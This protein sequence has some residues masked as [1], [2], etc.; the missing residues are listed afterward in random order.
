MSLSLSDS[1]GKAE[2]SALARGPLSATH[3]SV[4]PR[5]G[6]TPAV[7]HP[8]GRDRSS[9][10]KLKRR[11]S[12]ASDLPPASTE[13]RSAYLCGVYGLLLAGHAE[14]A[15]TSCGWWADTSRRAR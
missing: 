14:G 12:I 7:L 5:A 4:G 3:Q 11:S 2:S 13:N 9:L 1:I 8:I 6:S 15:V 10:Q